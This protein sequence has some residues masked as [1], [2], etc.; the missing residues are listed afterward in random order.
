MSPDWVLNWLVTTEA[1]WPAFLTLRSRMRRHR[2][3]DRRFVHCEGS[4]LLQVFPALVVDFHHQT[5]LTADS[6][7]QPIRNAL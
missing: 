4:M 6:D 3:R 5:K 1:T 7:S 2:H